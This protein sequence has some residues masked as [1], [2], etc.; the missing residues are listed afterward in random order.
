MLLRA[1]LCVV[2]LS[3][4]VRAEEFLELTDLKL[5][6]GTGAPERA[7]KRLVARDG[8]IVAIDDRGEVPLPGKG[9]RWTKI[10]LD[11]AF[12]MPGLVDTHVHVARFPDTRVHAE[13]ILR[14]ALR[15]GVTLVRDLAGD[16]RALADIER[17]VSTGELVAP[18]VVFSALLGGPDIFAAGPTS[19]MAAGREPGSAPW[20]RLVDGDSDLPLLIAEAKGTG[21]GN[22]K[23]YG[24]MNGALAAR[25]VGEARRQDMLTTAHGT[26][27]TARPSELVRAGVGSLAHAPYLV[28]EAV[29]EVPDDFR[30]RTQAPWSQIDP[31]RDPKLRALYAEMARRGVFLDATLWVFKAMQGYSPQVQ[32]DWAPVAF[33]WGA[34]ATRA[35]HAAGVRVTTGTDWFEPR[36]EMGL[37]NTHEELALLVEHA[38]FSP[39]DAILAGT[40]NGAAALGRERTHGTIEVGK[41]ADLLV[42]EESPLVDIRN[43]TTI[44]MTVRKG[45]VVSP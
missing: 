39:M 10:A 41:V 19:Q 4:P 23:L 24:D 1:V 6:D 17:A 29:D 36:E 11:G 15:G 18:D 35:A 30:K 16:A 31:E 42:L 34:K 25:I 20:A 9:A 27:F 37:P 14:G 22:L 43:T 38:G 7:V 33:A 8:V 44:R 12:V 28:W 26:V 45:M 2:V 5:I 40:R 3:A 13:R 32:A 21:A